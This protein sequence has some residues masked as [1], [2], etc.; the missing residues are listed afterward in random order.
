MDSREKRIKR[1]ID[2]MG[3]YS[4]IDRSFIL[5]FVAAIVE[6][7]ET[8]GNTDLRRELKEFLEY[9]DEQN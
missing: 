4:L 7:N 6:I 3:N 2:V 8:V 5:P 1:V 9:T